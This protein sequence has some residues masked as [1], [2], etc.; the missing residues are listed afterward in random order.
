MK[1]FLLFSSLFLFSVFSKGQIIVNEV[2]SNTPSTDTK[3]FIE[4]LTDSQ[5]MS[6]DG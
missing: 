6:L 3:E 5:N 2:D 1:H 4:L